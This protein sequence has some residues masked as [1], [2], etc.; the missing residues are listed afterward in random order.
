MAVLTREQL[1]SL[2]REN[3]IA[4]VYLFFGDET[5]LRDLAVKTISDKLFG[6]GDLR[7]FNETEVSLSNTDLRDALAAADQLPMMSQKR[8]VRVTEVR[9]SDSGRNVTVREEHETALESYLNNPNPSTVV[10]FVADDLDKRRKVSKLLLEKTTAVEF[11]ALS[12]QEVVGWLKDRLKEFNARADDNV[13]RHLVGLIGNDLRKVSGEL[14]KLAVASLPDGVVTVGLIDQLISNSRELSNFALTDH[15]LA[16]NRSRALETVHKLLDD[17]A[18]PVMLLGLIASNYHRLALVKDL[19]KQ[20]MD[21]RDVARAVN[22]PYSK[23]EEFMTM[24]RRLETEKLSHILRRMAEVDL[25]IKTSLA[26]PR[27]QI[28]MLVCE[29]T[30]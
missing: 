1:R 3:R 10:F 8:V 23:Q 19:M 25:A 7:E 13:L 2:I 30:S 18:E 4:P 6:E 24:A 12:D 5:Y 28:E 22:M 9:I 26:T 17:G 21:R 11:A 20:G 16:K 29:L 27:L 15:L 14:E